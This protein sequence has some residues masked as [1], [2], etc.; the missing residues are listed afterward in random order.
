M[1]FNFLIFWRFSALLSMKHSVLLMAK[2]TPNVNNYLHIG[3][4]EYLNNTI[5]EYPITPQ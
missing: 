4:I 5:E 2:I 1:R 3:D